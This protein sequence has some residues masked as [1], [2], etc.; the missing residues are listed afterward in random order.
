MRTLDCTSALIGSSFNID[1]PC[2]LRSAP[3][4]GSGLLYATFTKY[5]CVCACSTYDI[6]WRGA[7]LELLDQLEAENPEDP[8][9]APKVLNSLFV[10]QDYAAHHSLQAGGEPL[11]QGVSSNHHIRNSSGS[12]THSPTATIVYKPAAA[13]AHTHE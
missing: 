2:S 8:A 11:F 3:P 13:T 5:L 4:N 1:D 12:S 9:L 10:Q 7:M 6:M